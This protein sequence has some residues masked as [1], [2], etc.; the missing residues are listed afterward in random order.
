[1][2]YLD[3][4]EAKYNAYLIEAAPEIIEA[5]Y[6]LS[7]LS[8]QSDRYHEDMDF[9]DAVDNGLMIINKVRNFKF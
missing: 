6:N 4:K 5:L 8:L 2:E 7:V 3:E 9:R 1:M